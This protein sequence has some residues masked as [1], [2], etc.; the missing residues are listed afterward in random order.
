MPEH[1]D[2]NPYEK[3]EASERLATL[4]RRQHL[5]TAGWLIVVL[6]LVGGA[7]YAYPT[8]IRHKAAIEQF[9]GVHKTVDAMG[10][11]IKQTDAKLDRWASDQQN[12]R[13]QMS[14]LGQRMQARMTAAA[15]QAQELSAAAYQRAQAQIEER[16]AGVQARLSRIESARDADQNQLAALRRELSRTQN[17]LSQQAGELAAVRNQVEANGAAHDQELARL[18][19]NEES[20][21][22]DVGAIEHQLAVHRVNFEVAKNHST[23]LAEGISLGITGTDVTHRYVT[24]WMWVLPDRRTIW[25]KNQNAN[26]PVT[27]YGYGDG[28]KRELVITGVTHDSA[29]GYLLLPGESDGGKQVAAATSSG[30]E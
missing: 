3:R 7:W 30:G 28:K 12:L 9:A 2:H 4:N 25:L 20:N 6:A 17:E 29:V 22:R 18:Q 11:Q 10:E 26:Q 21:H 16:I 19:A 14:K 15:K 13:D 23:E 5:L 1:P 8:L 24:G 27:Y